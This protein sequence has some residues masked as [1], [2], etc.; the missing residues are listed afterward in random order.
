M[1]LK[2]LKEKTQELHNEAERYNDARKVI[3]HTITLEEYKHLLITNYG[4]YKPIEEFISLHRNLLPENLKEFATFHKSDSITNDLMDLEVDYSKEP[5]L[6]FEA[7][8]DSS[9]YLIG[10][11]YVLEGSMMGGL[12]ISKQLAKCPHLSMLP[13]QHFFSRDVEATLG[14]WEHFKEVVSAF[15]YTPQEIKTAIDAAN[16]A[17]SFFKETH[18]YHKKVYNFL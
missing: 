7:S 9:S 13:K 12:M 15:N 4:S 6:S 11:M 10:L 14:R 5:I 2:E 8:I 1:I 18:I 3:D 17:F 16:T